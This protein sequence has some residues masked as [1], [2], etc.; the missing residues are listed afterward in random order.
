MRIFFL[1]ALILCSIPCAARAAQVNACI[2]AHGERVYTDQPCGAQETSLAPG[3]SANGVASADYGGAAR[4]ARGIQGAGTVAECPRS[5]QSL[6]DR[7][8]G[9]FSS[10]DPNAL[11]G[12]LLW[13]G[14]SRAEAEARMRGFKRWLQSPLVGVDFSGSAAAPPASASSGGDPARQ[15][16]VAAP[17]GDGIAD[18]AQPGDAAGAPQRPDALTVLT[19]PRGGAADDSAAPDARSFGMVDQGGCWWLTF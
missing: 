2:G 12:V 10:D 8:A 7:V 9:A 16:S 4:N 18:A 19:Q 15:G 6:R 14:V 17:S 13:R 1:L 3:E 11:S 5:P